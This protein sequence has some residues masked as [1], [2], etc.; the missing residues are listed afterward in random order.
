M[1]AGKAALRERLRARREAVSETEAAR[2]SQQL[3]RRIVA[4]PAFGAAR[5]VALFCAFGSELDP[6]GV[7]EQ[8]EAAGK[9]FCLPRTHRDR[10]CL[11][12]HILPTP[13]GS[14]RASV[15]E[16]L[17]PGVYGILEPHGP[18]LPLDALDLVV[19]PA[20]CFDRAGYR[21]GWGGGYYDRVLAGLPAR[22]VTAV[23]GFD[24]QL[25]E[26]V[27]REDHDRPVTHL[28]TPSGVSPAA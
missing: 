16:G 27:P 2:A 20:L 25:V 21:L 13:P 10:K 11:T 1:S 6:L 12:F 5:T 15:R 4:L 8:P 18:E 14:T 9:R 3:A 24:F 17:V 22:T 23:V 28:V 19:V 26:E 7:V